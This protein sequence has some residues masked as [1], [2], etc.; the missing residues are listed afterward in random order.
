MEGVIDLSFFLYCA[1]PVITGSVRLFCALEEGSNVI[2]I[3]FLL[4]VIAI[5]TVFVELDVVLDTLVAV[6]VSD[7]ISN[8]SLKEE[9]QNSKFKN[10][11]KAVDNV[12]IGLVDLGGF[13]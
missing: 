8:H 6:P 2:D 13:W 3:D 7:N 12:R 5:I 11:E 9:K 1:K 10:P 4:L